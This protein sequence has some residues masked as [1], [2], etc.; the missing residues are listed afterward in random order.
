MWRTFKQWHSRTAGFLVIF[1]ISMA[2]LVSGC[3]KKEGRELF[4]RF[5]DKTWARFNLLSFEIPVEKASIY[6]ISLFARFEPGY[7]YETLDFN[8]IMNTPAGE[9][10]INEYK[11]E[12]KGK[13]GEF[14]I[15]CN[16]DSCQGSVLLKKEISFAKPGLLKIEIENLMPR[17]NAEGVIGVGIRLVPVG[18]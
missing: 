13:S 6:D 18:K 15:E 5:P 16:Q 12:V 8:M 4:H 14:S 3:G 17:L 2:F 7:Q 11:M 9:E 10:R 1:T